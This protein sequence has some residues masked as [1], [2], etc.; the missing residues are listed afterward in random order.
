MD[1]LTLALVVAG[2]TVF[3]AVSSIDNAVI[4]ADVL[5]TVGPRARRFFITWGML[6]AVFL[7]R[8]LLPWFIVFL[9][10]PSLGFV[11]SLTATFSSDPTVIA[12]VARSAPILLMGGGVFLIFLFCHW[13]FL[14]RKNHGLFAECF[15]E[16]QAAWFYALVSVILAGIVWYAL[17]LNP[18]VAFGAVVGST[19]FF[20]VH[21][22]RHQAEATERTLHNSSLTDVGKI[23]YLEVID[24]SFS[25]DG[26]LGA[27]AFT[28]SVPLILLGNGLG[29]VIVRQLTIANIERVRRYLFLKNGAMY[30]VLVLGLVMV[31]EGF[32]IHIPQ[33]FAPVATFLIIGYFVQKSRRVVATADAVPALSV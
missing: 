7:V 19:A 29:A 27:F 4:N 23:M 22:F 12:A 2:L 5:S 20:I 25:I 8:G 32:G 3:E 6:S 24:L 16:R 1:W 9:A 15:F 11:G 28:L 18:L 31:A 10:L 21:G 13:L 30:S 17:Q 14:E 26:V 33:W